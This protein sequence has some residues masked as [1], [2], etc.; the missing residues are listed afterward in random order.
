MIAKIQE[1]MRELRPHFIFKGIEVGG[2]AAVVWLVQVLH[3]NS[4]LVIG[5]GS[6]VGG[7]FF[8][9]IIVTLVRQKSFTWPA[10]PEKTPQ[11]TP[12][13]PPAGLIRVLHNNKE[14]ER[15]LGKLLDH[16]ARSVRKVILIQYSGRKIIDCVNLLWTKTGADID[17]YLVDPSEALSLHQ[18]RRIQTTLDKLHAVELSRDAKGSGTLRVYTYRAPGSVRAVLIEGIAAFVGSYFYRVE[19][20]GPGRTLE[21]DSRGHDQPL[22]MISEENPGFPLIQNALKDMVRTWKENGFRTEWTAIQKSDL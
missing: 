17:L 10:N 5:V 20:V 19:G 4:S 1:T 16:D 6:F 7:M 9:G 22:L 13:A 2:G 11:S 14:M 21:M 15:E 12:Q 18:E 8:T 3:T